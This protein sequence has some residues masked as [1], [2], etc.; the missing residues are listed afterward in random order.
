MWIPKPIWLYFVLSNFIFSCQQSKEKEAEIWSSFNAQNLSEQYPYKVPITNQFTEGFQNHKK[1]QNDFSQRSNNWEWIGPDNISGRILSLAIDPRDTN[2]LWAGTA[3]SGLWKSNSGGIGKNAWK[4]LKTNYPVRAVSSIAIDP[5]NSNIMYIASG[6]SYSYDVALEGKYQRTLRGSWGIGILKSEDGG[7]NWQPS[8][9]WSDYNSRTIWKIII[10]PV[11]PNTI[12]AAGTHGIWK[13]TDQGRLWNHILDKKMCNEL[14]IKPDSSNVIITG[15]GGIGGEEYGIY[16]SRDYGNSWQKLNNIGVEN[17][18][19]RIMIDINKNFPEKAFALLSDTFKTFHLLKTNNFFKNIGIQSLPDVTSYQGWYADGIISNGDGKLVLLGGVDLFINKNGVFND[20]T[21]YQMG[22][23]GVHPDF[24]DIIAN[25]LDPNKIYFATDGGVFRTNDFGT[26][27]FPC[28]DGLNTNQFYNVSFTSDG[29]F[30]IGGL[31]DNRSAIYTGSK[32]WQLTHQGDGIA[33]AINYSN[34]NTIFCCSQNLDL[35][36]SIDGG[37]SWTSVLR[38]KNAC[39]ASPFKM[40]QSNE[41][42]LYAGA[43][44]L[45]KSIDNGISFKSVITLPSQRIINAIEVSNKNSE[46]ILISTLPSDSTKPELYKSL[47]GGQSMIK[48]TNN[49][50]DRIITDISIINENEFFICLSGF[51]S[52]HVYSTTNGGQSWESIDFNL[53]DIPIHTIWVSPFHPEL[54]YAGSDFG[55]YYTLDKGS[56]WK[57]FKN[58]DYDLLTVYDLIYNEEEGKL[59]IATHGHG[60]FKIDPFFVLTGTANVNKKF[61]E[62]SFYLSSQLPDHLMSFSSGS[63]FNLQGQYCAIIKNDLQNHLAQFPKGVY[64]Y[65]TNQRVIRIIND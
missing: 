53:P 30:G 56:K 41:N 20:F 54:I 43:N 55:L 42:V 26:S 57:S 19:G 24:H 48:I 21:R 7:L 22:I 32:S 62:N 34:K 31:Q 49:L 37:N 50:P 5:S 33:S 29:Q 10:D 27:F 28:N 58:N 38:D 11:N 44:N 64:F 47:N 60:A 46:F 8:L 45:Y 4:Y 39:F 1:L 51:G 18:Q 59:V 3:S 2:V 14:V 16:I 35:S 52:K 12:Y 13:S 9:N 40:S 17:G 25:P 63:L 6:E 65:N 61:K 23:I 15:I 36:R